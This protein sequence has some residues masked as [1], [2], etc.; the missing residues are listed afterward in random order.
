MNA[1]YK[2]CFSLL[3]SFTVS[4][5]LFGQMRKPEEEPFIPGN[6]IVQIEL[7]VN[8]YNIVENLPSQYEF[9]VVQELS[10][11]L[12]AWLVDFNE[13]ALGQMDA[14]ALFRSIPGISLVQNNH[15]VELREIPNDPQFNQQWHHLNDGSNSGTIDAD[16]DSDEAWEI[17]TGGT[18]ALGHDIVVCILEGVDFSHVDLIDNRWTNP[19]EIAGNGLD[20]DG[21]GYIDDV[22][23]WNVG[24]NT[25]NLTGASTSHGT[26]VAGMIGAKGNNNVGVVGANWNVKM[27][28]VQGYNINTEASV[29]SAYNYPLT[30]RKRYNET[31][32]A[33]GAFV[34]ATNA[35]WGIDGANPNNYPLWCGFY[36]TLGVHGILNCGATTNSNLNVDVSGDMPTACS[37]PY[38]VGVGRSDRNDNFA[39]GYGLTTIDFAAPGIN[40]RTTANGN[41]YTTTTG[42][43]FSSPL[44]AGII[45]L[46]YA[47]PCESFMNSVIDNPQFGSDAVLNALMTGI[48][49]KPQLTNF[50]ISGGRVNA[51][52]SMDILMLETCNSCS[53]PA[54]LTSSTVS[55]TSAI[56]NFNLVNEATS[57]TFFYRIIGSA[58]WTQISVNSSP[59]NLSGL[60][61]CTSYE[62]YL[63][64]VCPI[65]TSNNTPVLSFL[66]KGCGACIDLAYCVSA[67]SAA[68]APK[69]QIQTPSNLSTT[70]TNYTLTSGWGASLENGYSYGN[71]V[72]VNDGTAS[73]ELGCNPLVNNAALL[74]NIAVALRGTCPFSTK[75]MAAQNAGATAL[76]IINNQAQAPATLSGGSESANVTIPVILISQVQGAQLLTALQNGETIVGFLGRQKEWIQ[77]IEILGDLF[78]T[79][80]NDGYTG[81]I[82]TQLDLLKGDTYNVL[83]T[84]GFAGQPLPEYSRIWLD[85]DLNG[86]FES[87]ELVYDQGTSSIGAVNASITIP[88]TSTIGLSR[89]RVQMVY[90]GFGSSVLPTN[91]GLYQFGETEDYCINISSNVSLNQFDQVGISMYPN[92]SNGIVQFRSNNNEPFDIQVFSLSGQM[93]KQQQ[94]SVSTLFMDL[95]HLSEGIYTVCA[96]SSTGGMIQVQKLVLLK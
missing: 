51:K 46:L 92:P 14:I 47:I 16:I 59:I 39:G 96:K 9:R 54:Q 29:I 91:C 3:M 66:T 75:A 27:C 12:R 71:L 6:L 18:N 38:M 95:N 20:D 32:G 5:A 63:N 82:D 50:F 84:P 34:V 68:P 53:T 19:E 60:S 15:K 79:G 25:G 11:F 73:P 44:T 45:S 85:T 89:M 69:F 64:A 72:L 28:N 62:Y 76:I 21:N 43:S 90:Q 41:A 7:D 80:N 70:I 2:L 17:T 56:I 35:S 1:F 22:F 74:G 87:N 78:S 58:N 4:N 10:P 55:E 81:P 13:Q 24:S 42:T 86:L 37:S 52:T 57:Y 8:L 83:L 65:E 77:S 94:M 33:N 67:T 36:D 48:D 26:N 23:G 49:Q 31:N 30:L 40:V 61:I 93:V 88:L